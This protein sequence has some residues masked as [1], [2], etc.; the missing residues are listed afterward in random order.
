[1]RAKIYLVL[2]IT[3]CIPIFFM[4]MA[5]GTIGI[6]YM[7]GSPIE[8]CINEGNSNFVIVISSIKMLGIPIIA[9]A[10]MEANRHFTKMNDLDKAIEEQRLS[11]QQMK[12]A[13]DKYTQLIRH[14]T[15]E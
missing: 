15:P 1:M 8:W 12:A 10:L 13:R 11:E 7:L 6:S 14:Y 4:S 2:A 9:M 3:F 5:D